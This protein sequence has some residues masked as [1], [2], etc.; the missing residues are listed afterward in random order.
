MFSWIFGT[1]NKREQQDDKKDD[2]LPAVKD[3]GKESEVESGSEDDYA[4]EIPV[5][6]HST[7]RSRKRT[8]PLQRVSW[9]FKLLLR[10]I[11]LFIDIQL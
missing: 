2:D 10:K 7:R 1:S 11:I 5:C 4:A 9:N 3:C 6:L 8:G